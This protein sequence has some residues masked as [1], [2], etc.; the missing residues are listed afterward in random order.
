MD[1]K[2]YSHICKICGR[3]LRTWRSIQRG[4]GATCE[5]KYLDNLYKTRQINF[6]TILDKNNK[7]KER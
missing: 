3:K 7:R 5:K 6:D 2:N 1:S 4:V